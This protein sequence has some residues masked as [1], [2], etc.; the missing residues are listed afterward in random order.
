VDSASTDSIWNPRLSMLSMIQQTSSR[1]SSLIQFKKLFRVSF[2]R[3]HQESV[4][5]DS[6]AI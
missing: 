1:T 4:Q 5:I 6:L 2:D 3:F